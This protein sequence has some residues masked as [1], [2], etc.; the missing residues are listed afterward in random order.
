MKGGHSFGG[1]GKIVCGGKGQK[2]GG[3]TADPGRSLSPSLASR[4]DKERCSEESIKAVF[5][6][7]PLDIEWEE[8]Q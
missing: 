5:M 2:H 8:R 7:V 6:D 4:R 1:G 3:V